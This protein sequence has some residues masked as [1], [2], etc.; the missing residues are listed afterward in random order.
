MTRAELDRA[1]KLRE[2]ARARYEARHRDPSLPKP[3]RKPRTPKPRR[4]IISQMIRK[5]RAM[6][7]YH[8]SMYAKKIVRRMIEFGIIIRP[9]HCE[10]VDCKAGGYPEIHHKDPRRPADVTFL[11]RKCRSLLVKEAANAYH[12]MR[13]GPA[14]L[15]NADTETPRPHDPTILTDPDTR[16]TPG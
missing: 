2:L 10:S 16:S 3:P 14:R 5:C 1:T 15:D 8:A 4:K 6:D 12:A 11:C 9:R 7:A 13:C